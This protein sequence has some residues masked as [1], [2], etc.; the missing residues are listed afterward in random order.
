MDI[1]KCPNSTFQNTFDFF[2]N[3]KLKKTCCE[4]KGKVCFLYFQKALL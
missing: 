3:E 1:Y 2:E 4:Q